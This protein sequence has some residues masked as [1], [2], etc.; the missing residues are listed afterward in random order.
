M[1]KVRSICLHLL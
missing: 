1:K